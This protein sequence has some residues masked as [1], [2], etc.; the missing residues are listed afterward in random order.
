METDTMVGKN[1]EDQRLKALEV[2]AKA[3]YELKAEQ[4]VVLDMAAVGYNVTDYF[5][6]ATGLTKEHMQAIADRIEKELYSE[7]GIFVDHIEGYEGGWWL[8]MDYIDFVVH[9]MSEEAREYYM[10]EQL[11]GD[12]PLLRYPED[13]YV[14]DAE[15][16]AGE[17]N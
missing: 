3:A 2:A 11:W 1:Q 6:I 7:L 16:P 10:L 15:K 13:F 4:I 9:I 17:N 14:A 12:A 8:L 5:L